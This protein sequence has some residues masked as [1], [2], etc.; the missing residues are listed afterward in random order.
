[1]TGRATESGLPDGEQS[2]GDEGNLTGGHT[3]FDEE[4]G[5]VS[6]RW[7]PLPRVTEW[8]EFFWTSGRDGKLR[9]QRCADCGRFRHPPGP[10]CPYCRSRQFEVASASGR[11]TISSVTVNHHAWYPWVRTPYAIIGVD[12]DEDPDVRLLASVVDVDQE[13]VEIGMRVEVAFEHHGD[14]W[15]PCFRPT[16]EKVMATLSASDVLT[17]AINAPA[18]VNQVSSAKDRFEHRSAITGIGISRLGRRLGGDPLRFTVDACLRA[19]EDAGL[20]LD[21][22][23]GLSTYPGGPAAKG[24]SEGGVFALEEAL[25]VRPTW[26]N[27]ASESHGQN[28]LVVAA[29][30]A[31]AAGLCRHVL[32][33]RTVWESTYREEIRRGGRS[34]P[35][36]GPFAYPNADPVEGDDQWQLPFGALS[37]VNIIAGYA[38]RYMHTYGVGREALGHIA[39]NARVNAAL[40]PVAVYRQPID[41]STYLSAPMI[42]SPFGLYDC[43]VP[44]DGAIAVVVSAV[45]AAA[46]CRHR[47]VRFDAVGTKITERMPWHQGVVTHEPQVFGPAQHLWSRT[48]LKP[49]DVDLAELYDGFTFNALTWLEAF[50][51][52][53]LGEA[54]DYIDDGRTIALTGSL[55]LNTHG[56]QLAEGRTHGLGFLREAVIQLRGDAGVRQVGGAEVALVTSGGM[57][58]GGALLLTAG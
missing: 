42:S 32:C 9:F 56:G 55:P 40:N 26:I 4:S 11:G 17:G 35:Q 19:V 27:G 6:W 25:R 43:D 15:I 57:M 50:G 24:M 5:D 7:P 16:G 23:D 21:D 30:L 47:P 14:V 41:M 10:V 58:P 46:D 36:T 1:M 38:N 37:P 8:N 20:E 13:A 28:G 49:S 2:S 53:G 54:G 48:D 34:Y 3:T 18:A 45:D 52:C 22:I 33:F 39:V 29:M 44:C 31:V 12:I 51:F